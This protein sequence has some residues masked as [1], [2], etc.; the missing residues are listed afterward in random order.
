MKYEDEQDSLLRNNGGGG[1]CVNCSFFSLP[2]V[3]QQE[4]LRQMYW[5][6]RL[7]GF[8]LESGEKFLKPIEIIKWFFFSS[9]QCL[10]CLITRIPLYFF[11]FIF[12]VIRIAKE[13]SYLYAR[14][15]LLAPLALAQE[16]FWDFAYLVETIVMSIFLMIACCC[17]YPP[18]IK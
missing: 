11:G 7:D 17:C 5:E 14:S 2:G 12:D 4:S 15:L 18:W 3:E 16:L 8:W 10:A 6:S 1:D 13:D 9:A